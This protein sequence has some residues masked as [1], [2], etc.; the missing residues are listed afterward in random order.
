ML[1]LEQA[2]TEHAK[3]K[4]LWKRKKNEAAKLIKDLTKMKGRAKAS[5]VGSAYNRACCATNQRVQ[6]SMLTDMHCGQFLAG[7][8]VSETLGSQVLRSMLMRVLQAL[9]LCDV[10]PVLLAAAG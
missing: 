4:K 9:L 7:Q 3:A 5:K 8:P 10:C 6:T 2:W 1:L